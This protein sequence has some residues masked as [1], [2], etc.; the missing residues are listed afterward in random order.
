M[1]MLEQIRALVTRWRALKEVESLTD[2]DLMDLGMTRAQ[3]ETFARM[4]LDVA[5]RVTAMAT[6]FG[7]SA[8]D[9]KTNYPEY[10][11]LL[12]AC[13]RCHDRA[14]CGLVLAKGELARPSDAAFCPNAPVF[15]QKGNL[16]A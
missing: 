8:A 1:V 4:P 16:A 11:D 14:A 2:R 6:N 13:G 7:I 5:D 9:L 15:A 3:V 10:L 12:T